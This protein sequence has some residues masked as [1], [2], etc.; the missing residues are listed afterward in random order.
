MSEGVAASL[1]SLPW[2]QVSVARLPRSGDRTYGESRRIEGWMF[3]QALSTRDAV[4]A[5]A[6]CDGVAD[7]ELIASGVA[8]DSVLATALNTTGADYTNRLLLPSE[9]A[10]LLSYAKRKLVALLAEKS[11][12]P[13]YLVTWGSEQAWRRFIVQAASRG[14]AVGAANVLTGNN[15]RKSIGLLSPLT[16]PGNCL[17]AN[18]LQTTQGG[19]YKAK[20]LTI[21]KWDQLLKEA[22]VTS[23]RIVY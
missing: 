19:K 10:E 21:K 7:R 23:I 15:A 1:A 6:H 11:D 2:F 18:Y 9:Y 3:V 5:A 8:Q 17:L 12:Y 22:G 14:A 20:A 4:I 13:W 16:D